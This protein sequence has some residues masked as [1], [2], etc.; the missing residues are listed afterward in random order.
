MRGYKQLVT[1]T[2]RPPRKGEVDGITYHF[3]S[4]KEFIHKQ[5]EGFFAESTSYLTQFGRWYYG[6]AKEDYAKDKIMIANPD[7][8]KK[9]KE[10]KDLNPVVFYIMASEKVI[11]QR[12][13]KRGDDPFEAQRRLEQD[14]IDFQGINSYVDYSIRND[15]DLSPSVIA[16]MILYLYQKG[17]HVNVT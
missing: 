4:E 13:T 1:Y 12:L 6:S 14:L 3:I 11:K 10:Q 9:I 17:G 15:G 16:D 2:T 7:G 5:K 8:V